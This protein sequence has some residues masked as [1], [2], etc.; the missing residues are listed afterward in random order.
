MHLH[1]CTHLRSSILGVIIILFFRCMSG[2][3]YPVDRTRGD[4]RKWPLV[5]YVMVTFSIAII[6]NAPNFDFLSLQYIDNRGFPGDGDRAP[7]GPIGYLFSTNF[8]VNKASFVAVFLNLW[9]TD[10]LLV[11]AVSSPVS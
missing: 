8:P 6:S 4:A 3:L 2:L 5:A 1:I 11:S 9:L 7:A 10:G